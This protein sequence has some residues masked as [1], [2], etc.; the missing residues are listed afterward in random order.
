MANCQRAGA[1]RGHAWGQPPAA[2]GRE[3]AASRDGAREVPTK[4][5]DHGLDAL[6]Y[7]VAYVDGLDVA[8]LD[9]R[10]CQPGEIEDRH[11]L[12]WAS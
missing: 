11:E 3:G 8:Q 10:L 1:Y 2:E 6:R 4:L 9:V 5:N 7:A 12:E